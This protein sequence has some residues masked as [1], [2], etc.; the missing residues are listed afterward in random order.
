MRSERA[1]HTLQA[2]A[3]VNEAYMRLV[4]SEVQWQDRAHFIAVAARLMRRILVDYARSRQ[5]QKR[6]GGGTNL[7]LDESGVAAPQR[8]ADLLALDEALTRFAAFDERK[9]QI[10]E[11]HFFGGLTYD[12]T[13][14]VLGISAAT[15]DRDLRLA[16]AWLSRNLQANAPQDG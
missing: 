2:T 3:L 14:E 12:E 7:S 15:V 9:S 5:A 4:E 11:L 6:S 13:A 1:S 10:V 16:K 8:S